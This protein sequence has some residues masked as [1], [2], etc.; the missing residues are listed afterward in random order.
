MG[1]FTDLA[2]VRPH[3]RRL[4][5]SIIPRLALDSM[6]HP[7]H[8][9]L[10]WHHRPDGYSRDFCSQDSATQSKATAVRDEELGI[11]RK[12]RREPYQCKVYNDGVSRSAICDVC[13]GANLGFNHGLHEL[14][15]RVSHPYKDIWEGWKELTS[16][17]ILYLFFEAV[18][19]PPGSGTSYTDY[20]KFPISF[21][22]ERGWNEGVGALPFTAFIVGIAMG[23]GLIA[24]STRTN[25]TRAFVKH[26]KII[27]EER[28]PPM[29]LGAAALPIGLFWFAWWVIPLVA[30]VRV[31]HVDVP[32]TSN[33]NITWVPQVL[34]VA[35]LGG[36]CLVTFWQGMNY[37]IDC[38]GFYSNSA[39]A[40]NTFVRS[41]A[42]A[43]FPL[44]APAMYQNLGVPWA[45][46]LL[47]FLCV[48]FLPVP[49]LFYKYGAKIRQRSRFRPAV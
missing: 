7:H 37:I 41:I 36:G 47:G 9:D 49:I 43:G 10:I 11:A 12:S 16:C 31:L 6:D 24:Y 26:G 20:G 4:H 40:I 15:L 29:I 23:T 30:L 8:C 32:R 14:Y 1:A 18:S 48:A 42:G 21:Q 44:F 19:I 25:F 33:P 28:L 3:H 27:P 5:H 35:L 17:R 39:I 22:G 38:Y 13:P 34:S 46:S 2:R 45:T